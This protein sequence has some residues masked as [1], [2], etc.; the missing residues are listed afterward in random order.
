MLREHEVL[1]QT[2][3]PIAGTPFFREV[4]PEGKT[5][6]GFFLPGGTEI[7]NRKLKHNASSLH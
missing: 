7:G 5:I 3:Y 2:S 1:I 4:P 6:C